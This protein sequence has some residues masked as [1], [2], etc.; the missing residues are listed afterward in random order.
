VD[1]NAFLSGMFF[2]S[3]PYD[4]PFEK[5]ALASLN[6]VRKQNSLIDARLSSILVRSARA[7][8]IYLMINFDRF[9]RAKQGD[10]TLS[11]HQEDPAGVGFT[12][13][14]HD[15]S[16]YFGARRAIGGENIGVFDSPRTDMQ[17]FMREQPPFDGHRL[18]VLSPTMKEM[19]RC[20]RDVPVS[21]GYAVARL[22]G[23]GTFSAWEI[24]P[25]LEPTE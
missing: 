14:G 13:V 16:V 19:C 20:A 23:V 17:G 25:D 21:F 10:H 2:D 18:L 15:R 12:G 5:D 6:E 11:F 22:G 3:E 24:D 9:N 1:I 7:H 8:V 4:G